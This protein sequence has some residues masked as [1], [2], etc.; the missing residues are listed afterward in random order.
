MNPAEKYITVGLQ[1]GIGNQLFQIAAG[2]ALAKRLGAKFCLVNY[3]FDGMGQGSHP[4]K[5]YDNV[6]SKCMF[7]DGLENIVELKQVGWKKQDQHL[8]EQS[9]SILQAGYNGI[10]LKGYFQGLGFFQDC[11]DEIR[12]L[13]TPT[14]GVVSYLSAKYTI[15]NRFPELK[16]SHEYGFIG[17]RRGDYLKTPEVHWPCGMTYYTEAMNRM[18][19][20]HYYIASDDMVWAKSNFH[21]AQFRFLDIT[22]DLELLYTM[23]LF[24]NYIISNSTYHWWGTFLSVYPSPRILAPNKWINI[25]GHEGIYTPSME[26]LERPVETA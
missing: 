26:V 12:A 21:G 18:G 5:Y 23:M 15:F 11:A 22:D 19:C 17:V 10:L 3:Q 6:F 7:V 9:V 1:G 20:V 4:T 8:E 16:D 14:E 2:Y 24:R 13:F 25:H